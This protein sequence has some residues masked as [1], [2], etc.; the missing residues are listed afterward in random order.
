M[1]EILNAINVPLVELK[2]PDGDS[3]IYARSYAEGLEASESSVPVEYKIDMLSY[4]KIG[5]FWGVS[6][7]LKDYESSLTSV[8]IPGSYQGLPVR[9]ILNGAF[10]NNT[11]IQDVKIPSSIRKIGNSAFEGC[12]SLSDVTINS[13]SQI[14]LYFRSTLGWEVVK[15]YRTQQNG[16]QTVSINTWPGETMQRWSNDGLYDIYRFTI[17]IGSDITFVGLDQDGEYK[18][19]ERIPRS[20]L[21]KDGCWEPYIDDNG[22]IQVRLTPYDADESL[23]LG[24]N[25]FKGCTSLDQI[26]LPDT[27]HYVP[28]GAFYNCTSLTKVL[29]D[30]H[31][32]LIGIGDDAFRGTKLQEI[33]N[34]WP[35]TIRNIGER[36]F[37]ECTELDYVYLPKSVVAIERAAFLGCTGIEFV[38][39]DSTTPLTNIGEQAFFGCTKLAT[40]DIPEMVYEIGQNAFTGCPLTSVTMYDPYGW[41][42]V[43]NE[44]NHGALPYSELMNTESA[45]IYLAGTF[46]KYKIDQMPPPE[47]DIDATTLTITDS[48]GIAEY[49]EIFVYGTK[50][51]TVDAQTGKVTII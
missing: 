9:E 30:L 2:L 27:I 1:A 43:A 47:L 29:F 21:V 48:T 41:F 45:G 46:R 26:R 15:C 25:I 28:E 51:A 40:I 17:P 12:T 49:F 44:N 13:S 18:E 36:A 20:S 23:T 31:I 16:N 50:W 6:G 33:P 19:T 37:S 14:V 35:Q 5:S 24:S 39:I 4:E 11:I 32:N 3:T 42:A 38:N 10:A 34:T 8:A 22:V 7:I